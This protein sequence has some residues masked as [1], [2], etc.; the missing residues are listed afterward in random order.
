VDWSNRADRTYVVTANREFVPEEESLE[1]RHTVDECERVGVPHFRRR[2]EAADSSGDDA[3]T[4]DF[5]M[6]RLLTAHREKLR[7]RQCR[8][9]RAHVAT[10]S[11]DGDRSRKLTSA[12]WV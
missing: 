1:D 11:G 4:E 9:V 3:E 2:G 8:L 5:R 6:L 7:V 12:G 10:Q